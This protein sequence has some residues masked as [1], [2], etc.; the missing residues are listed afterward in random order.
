MLYIG[1]IISSLLAFKSI[2]SQVNAAP[3][4]D[5]ILANFYLEEP[6]DGD[7]IS[8]EELEDGYADKYFYS[9]GDAM[10][11]YVPTSGDESYPRCE[12]REQCKAGSNDYNW[13]LSQGQ[14]QLTGIYEIGTSTTADYFIIAQIHSKNGPGK[15]L[16]K[17]RYNDGYIRTELKTDSSGSNEVKT[18]IKENGDDTYVGKGNQFEVKI[19]VKDTKVKVW[20]DDDRII[21]EDV[22]YWDDYLCYFKTGNYKTQYDSENVK[23]YVKI[24]SLSISHSESSSCIDIDDWDS[25]IYEEDGEG[26]Q[27]LT[28]AGYIVIIM[29]VLICSALCGFAVYCYY[30]K[31][32]L[33]SKGEATFRDSVDDTH[34]AGDNPTADNPAVDDGNNE[35]QTGAYDMRN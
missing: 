28:T 17:I 18:Q 35:T 12:L 10:A 22:S 21:Y 31:K 7:T 33:P 23:S 8:G 6:S 30:K 15:P 14:H 16:L 1:F 3:G 24:H 9:D 20:L 13:D 2:I 11:F 32:Y 29:G 34:T 5:F 19:Q 26:E 25:F 27:T 4:D